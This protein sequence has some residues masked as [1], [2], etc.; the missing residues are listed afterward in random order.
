M[1]HDELVNVLKVI[2]I[3]S[4]SENSKDKAMATVL[5]LAAESFTKDILNSLIEA[6]NTIVLNSL[7]H[8]LGCPPFDFCVATA[9]SQPH[10]IKRSFYFKIHR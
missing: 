3:A 2:N 4:V 10:Y 6:K 7:R 1:N 5:R 8:P 9:R